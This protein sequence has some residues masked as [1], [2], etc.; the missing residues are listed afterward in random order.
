MTQS[1]PYLTYQKK[2][3]ISSSRNMSV[4][5]TLNFR[6]VM[7]QFSQTEFP[8]LILLVL[9]LQNQGHK[10]ICITT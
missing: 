9:L 3:I 8:I 10:R 6:L 4:V 1:I 5:F 7:V 2:C